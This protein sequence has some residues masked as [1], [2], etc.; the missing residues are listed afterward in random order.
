MIRGR[1]L[2]DRPPREDTPIATGSHAGSS[3]LLDSLLRHRFALTWAVATLSVVVHI[4][5]FQP[6]G[7]WNYFELF[8]RWVQTRP[9][10]SLDF[11]AA[12]PSTWIGPLVLI[13]CAPLAQLPATVAVWVVALLLVTALPV[14]LRL[15]ERT[16]IETGIPDGRRLHA[17]SAA[18]GL[19]AIVCWQELSV[20]FVHPEDALVAVLGCCALLAVVRRR[21]W[22]A[23]VCLGL[24]ASGKPWAVGLLAVVLAAGTGRRRWAALTLGGL[25]AVGPWLP[26]V[27]GAPD[28]VEAL[29]TA[30]NTVVPG[31]PM[32]Q[33]G[34]A[35]GA[36]PWFTRPLQFGAVFAG[37]ALAV[38]A[39]RLDLVLVAGVGAR[40]A[41]EPQLWSYYWATLVVGALAADL[42]SRRRVPLWTTGAVLVGYELPRIVD[43][44]PNTMA[45]LQAGPLL[46]VLAVLAWGVLRER[47]RVPELRRLER[48]TG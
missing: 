10:Q 22:V 8:S 23:A 38:R 14:C 30:S 32:G 1:R 15:L 3:R 31:S 41:T 44:T 26:F 39:G 45:L 28:T 12:N 13:A 11:F 47:V 37:A 34:Y 48:A 20:T 16:A 27:L 18:G 40:L 46:V 19:L 17:V 24:A 42:L 21:P 9:G 5:V 33:F 2:P 4:T 36:F 35:D 7:D 29:R 43:V 25:L 6:P